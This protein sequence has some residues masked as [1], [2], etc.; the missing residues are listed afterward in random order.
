MVLNVWNVWPTL[1]QVHW[2]IVF[3][4]HAA[5]K[6]QATAS[7]V[8]SSPILVTLMKEELNSSE[9]SVLTRATRHNIP[10]DAILHS[11][12]TLLSHCRLPQ[13]GRSILCIRIPQEQDSTV[14]PMGT[15]YPRLPLLQLAGWRWRYCNPP[16]QDTARQVS[17]HTIC[18]VYK[19]TGPTILLLVNVYSLPR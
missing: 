8:P 1:R 18:T 13:P 15:G 16:P 4:T 12:N 11:N 6:H 14:I 2:V 9:T 3:D 5:N 17:F 10:E 7:V 19:M